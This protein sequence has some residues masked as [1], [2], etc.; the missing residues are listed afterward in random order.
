SANLLTGRSVVRTR[1]LLL[2]FRCLGLGDLAVSQSLCL[3]RV[4]LQLD[5]ERV[6]QLEDFSITPFVRPKGGHLSSSM[7][8]KPKN[9]NCSAATLFRCLSAMPPEGNTTTETP[10]G[11][12]GLDRSSYTA[13]VGLEPHP[14]RSVKLRLSHWAIQI[15][16]IH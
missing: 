5:T 2:D 6:L 16:A 1:P 11:C 12:S 15:S 8:T 4:A 7:Q 13:E 3:L 14:F 9:K 10:P